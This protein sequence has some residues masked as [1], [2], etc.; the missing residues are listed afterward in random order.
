MSNPL[1]CPPD[2]ETETGGGVTLLD[3]VLVL[4]GSWALPCAVES[5]VGRRGWYFAAALFAGSVGGIFWAWYC[6]RFE[7]L[8]HERLCGAGGG[9]ERHPG[10]LRLQVV[11]LV[12][13]VLSILLQYA[14]Y[15]VL[16]FILR[17]VG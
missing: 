2:P 16:G 17:A 6:K 11:Y 10:Y 12:V 1:S 7:W 3:F 5:A 14:L 4:S 8:I 15:G 9:P 13:L